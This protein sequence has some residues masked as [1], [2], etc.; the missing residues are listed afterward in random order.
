M[1]KNPLTTIIIVFAIGDALTA[2]QA[3]SSGRIEV[4]T[5]LAWLQGIVL[6]VLYLAK[7]KH[8]GSFLFYSGL[9]F[10]PIYFGLNALGWNSP[11]ASPQVVVI[12][13]AIYIVAIVFLWKVKREYEQYYATVVGPGSVSE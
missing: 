2:W 7:S 3:W 9:P 10:F 4:L 6:L 12:A 1:Q 13:L 11:R 8:A 5:A